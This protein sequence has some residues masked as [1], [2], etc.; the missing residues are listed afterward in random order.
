MSERTRALKDSAGIDTGAYRRAVVDASACPIHYAITASGTP[1]EK[2]SRADFAT[3]H[4]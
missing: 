2:R 3:S 1:R 4:D